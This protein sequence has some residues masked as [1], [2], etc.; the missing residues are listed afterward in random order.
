MPGK[1]F[2]HVAV[3]GSG[4]AGLVTARVL[5][6]FFE[7]V[8]LFEK[9]SV[10]A[11][12][13]FRPGVP[14]GRHFHALIPGGLEIMSQLLPGIME[15]L[16]EAGSLLPGPDQFYFF[17]PQGKSYAL[18][19]YVPEPPPDTGLRRMYVQTRGLLEHCVRARVELIENIETRY[20]TMIRE[21]LAAD[22]RVSGVV[23]DGSG[24]EVEADLVV[25]AAGRGGR[26]LQWLDR[27]G[28]DRPDEDVV[29]CD[30]AYTSVFMKPNDP[31]LFTDV[32]FFVLPGPDSEHTTRGA[33]LV[34][35]E[36]GLWL[37]SVGGRYG[38]F[39]PRDFE[40]FMTYAKTTPKPFFVDL[41]SQAEPVGEPAHYRFPKSVRR[42]FERLDAFPERLLP[43]GD[44]ICHYNPIY[45]QGM[46]A[47]S[48][49][50]IALQQV[51]EAAVK[52]GNGL[53]GIW[54]AFFPEA[55]QET[56]A[57]WL[58]AA[59]ADFGDPRCTGDFPTEETDT[60]AL[61]QFVGGLAQSGDAEA[62][63]TMASIGGLMNRL[64]ILE[65]PPWP[66]RLAASQSG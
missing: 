57:P 8:T 53:D 59:I 21:V 14:Q 7:K 33:A 46:S 43:I 54:K 52:S 11:S 16:R 62:Q 64:A 56:R 20:E 22:G 36:A 9:D 40:G 27:M 28:F 1:P 13:D 63:L 44:A 38:D 24:E 37:A 58:F 35:M 65:Q 60:L 23:V 32:G 41:I 15:D 61:M 50:G 12:P 31:D 47:A 3:L 30:F 10:P 51:M 18:G 6:D 4:M 34:R 49:Q 25:D 19:Q 55:Y 39:P 66:E 2:N 48:R 29:N 5:S 45:G 17:M 26:S 42:R